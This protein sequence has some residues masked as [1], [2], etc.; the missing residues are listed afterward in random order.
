MR[1]RYFRP[2]NQICSTP[3]LADAVFRTGWFDTPFSVSQT[4]SSINLHQN[5]EELLLTAEI[6]GIS[7]EDLNLKIQNKV[8]HINGKRQVAYPDDAKV[9]RRERGSREFNRTVE[10]PF[11]VQVDQCEATLKDGILTLKMKKAEAEKTRTILVS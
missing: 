3:D 2:F 7:K 1:R 9:L 4:S 10:L 8:L 11:E 5:A 6:P